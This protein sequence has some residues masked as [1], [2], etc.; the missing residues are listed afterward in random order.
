MGSEVYTVFLSVVK[1]LL[2]DERAL[3]PSS[4]QCRRVLVAEAFAFGLIIQMSV[5]WRPVWTD[6]RPAIG[7]IKHARTEAV[8]SA[9]KPRTIL[10]CQCSDKLRIVP[11]T[12]LVPALHAPATP[13]QKWL[14]I[15][16]QQSEEFRETFKEASVVI[17]GSRRSSKP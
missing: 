16:K 3:Y 2:L 17:M 5:S 1:Q 13:T 7:L 9:G 8:G 15:F 14:W 12:K 10:S 6:A 4:L 11:T